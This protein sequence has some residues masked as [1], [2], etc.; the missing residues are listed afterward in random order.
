MSL[1]FLFI[2]KIIEL[3]NHF[4]VDGQNNNPNQLREELIQLLTQYFQESTIH[5]NINHL[6]NNNN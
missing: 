5:V 6:L 2:V 3:V 1:E 4:D